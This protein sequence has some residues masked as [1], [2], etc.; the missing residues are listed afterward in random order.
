MNRRCQSSPCILFV[1]W[2]SETVNG[3]TILL[4]ALSVALSTSTHA[5][6]DQS[7]KIGLSLPLSGP[8]AEFGIAAKNGIEFARALNPA[9]FDKISFS[10]ED[11]KYDPK[12]A[13]SSFHKLVKSDGAKLVFVW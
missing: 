6:A 9:G 5:V 12:S 7:F 3:C 13:I 1:R 8:N 2:F 4:L 11:N 10:F